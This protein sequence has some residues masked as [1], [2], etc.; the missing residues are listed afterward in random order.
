M[1]ACNFIGFSVG[2][3]KL[4]KFDVSFVVMTKK[5]IDKIVNVSGSRAKCGNKRE[6]ICKVLYYTLRRKR[7][8]V[9]VK[10]VV[11]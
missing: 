4:I 9:H 2:V 1:Q 8:G 5:K 7:I 11:V 10:K 6:R 3:P